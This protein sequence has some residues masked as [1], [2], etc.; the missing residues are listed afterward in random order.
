[1]SF[2]I[3]VVK[4]QLSALEIRIVYGNKNQGGKFNYTSS[5]KLIVS[6][7]YGPSPYDH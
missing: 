5:K 2:T 6:T 3:P 7:K 4:S 1:M